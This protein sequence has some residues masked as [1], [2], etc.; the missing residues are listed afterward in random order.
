MTK[1]LLRFIIILSITGLILPSF[2][3][4]NSPQV[5]FA[6]EQEAKQYP[7]MPGTFEEAWSFIK[8]IIEPLPRAVGKVWQAAVGIWQRMAGWFRGVWDSKIW[9]K[10]D[11]IWQKV[12][13]IFSKEVEKRKE[14]LPQ[15]LEKEK[16]E[17]KEET[18][19]AG[20]SLWERLKDLI[21]R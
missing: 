20:K 6:Q 14:E 21:R 13:G 1:L 3:S 10:I 17:I 16:Q 5:V 12:F 8:R 7:K 4:I 19:K 15:E 11:W 2:G 9:P 18:S